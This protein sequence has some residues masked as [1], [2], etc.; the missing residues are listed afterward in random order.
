VSDD[1]AAQHV[2]RTLR[3]LEL[4]ARGSWLESELAR[5]LGLHPRTAKR[6]LGAL[7][8]NGYVEA[9]RDGRRTRYTATLAVVRLAGAVL[10]RTDLV[11]LAFPYVVRLRNEIGEA[12]HLGVPVQNGVMHL[13]QETSENVVMVKP[14]L[15]ERARY[16]STAVGKAVLAYAGELVNQVLDAPLEP[17]TEHTI[18]QPDELLLELARI[19]AQGF[20]V[21]DC[22]DSLDLRCVA[23]PVLDHSGHLVGAIGIS[24]PAYRLDASELDRLGLVV[25]RTAA[26]LSEALGGLPHARQSIDVPEG[27]ERQ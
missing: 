24:A 12:A 22:E 10:D 2:T 27:S 9:E 18:V 19:R 3:A 23:A 13:L 14:R 8:A 16:H 26:A 7:S 11:K 17:R 6:L 25:A 1:P 21:D 20:A 15:G 4:L 5:D